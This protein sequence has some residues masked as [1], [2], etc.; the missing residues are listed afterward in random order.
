[1]SSL[2]KLLDEL[3][4][5]PPG[6][7]PS[8]TS[9]Q[10]LD[11]LLYLGKEAPIGRKK[12]SH[13]LGIGEG[14]I[15]NMLNRFVKAGIVKIT[16]KGCILTTR[17]MKI[18][19][20]ISD[21]VREVGP[22]DIEIPWNCLYNFTVVVKKRSHLIKKGLEQ[23]DAA[24]KG[25]AEAAIIMTYVDG[26]LHMP[27]VSVLSDERPEFALKLIEKVKPE[28][29]D[30]IIIVGASDLNKARHGSLAAAQTLL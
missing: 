1:M 27:S 11:L 8:F 23:R 2:R 7:S 30:V 28:E 29:G 9:I 16:D 25:D 18:Y 17:G 21:I 4:K 6:P 14:V 19:K 12:L 10:M 20:Y 3:V 5:S 13:S 22:L 24:I 26:K 15:R